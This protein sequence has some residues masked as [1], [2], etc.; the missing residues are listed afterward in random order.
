[1]NVKKE[2]LGLLK[3]LPLTQENICSCGSRVSLPVLWSDYYCEVCGHHVMLAPNTTRAIAQRLITAAGMDPETVGLSIGDPQTLSPDFINTL[4]QEV[5]R[6]FAFVRLNGKFKFSCVNCGKCCKHALNS[7]KEYFANLSEDESLRIFGDA[8]Q[9]RLPLNEISKTCIFWDAKNYLCKI[10]EK[11]PT[12]CRLFP[13]Q[14]FGLDEANKRVRFLAWIPSPCPGV[15]QG[16]S[17]TVH[18]YLKVSGVL[19]KFI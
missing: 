15:G 10:H 19:H 6:N 3:D 2:I 13:F 4:R 12:F 14:T 18:K 1:M 16:Q 7:K 8:K 17:W 11:R 9:M 5:G